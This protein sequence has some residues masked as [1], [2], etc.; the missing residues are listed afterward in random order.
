M[1]EQAKQLINRIF[2]E[3]NVEFT[4]H[5]SPTINVETAV[6]IKLEPFIIRNDKE[7]EHKITGLWLHFYMGVDDADKVRI[8]G[9]V[10]RRSIQTIIE[11]HHNYLHSH[12]PTRKLTRGW[13]QFCL[14]DGEFA[15][16]Y[17]IA[18]SIGFEIDSLET[19]FMLLRYYLS[20]EDLSNPHIRL[21]KVLPL[22]SI[23]V[24]HIRSEY[25]S[26]LLGNEQ[27]PKL[28]FNSD[29]ELLDNRNNH[30]I[31]ISV[32]PQHKVLKINGQYAVINTN[33]SSGSNDYT[34]GELFKFKGKPVIGQIT[35]DIENVT[36]TEFT[37]Y[38][39]HPHLF[40]FLSNDFKHRITTRLIK[41]QNRQRIEA[42]EAY[43]SSVRELPESEQLLVFKNI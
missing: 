25:T 18:Q 31:L 12:L 9:L 1:I 32:F 11:Y 34:P 6:L 8:Y 35:T 7:Q 20:Y 42:R 39:I 24:L 23:P 21:E 10:S 26:T 15:M 22:T 17:Q 33:Y 28:E 16:R 2:K 36:F 30:D 5:R 4:E 43:Y 38:F 41:Q 14:G 19:F 27:L 40:N 37:E 13:Q 3:E 29:Y